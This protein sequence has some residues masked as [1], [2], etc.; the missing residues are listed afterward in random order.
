MKFYKITMLL[1]ITTQF[2][3]L[4]HASENKNQESI[5]IDEYNFNKIFNKSVESAKEKNKIDIVEYQFRPEVVQLNLQELTLKNRYFTVPYSANLE[6]IR[7]LGFNLDKKLYSWNDFDFSS[8]MSI[9]YSYTEKRMKVISNQGSSLTDFMRLHWFPFTVGISTL[10]HA[11]FSRFVSFYTVPK[12]GGQW[13]YQS[14]E[15]DG[16]SQ[17]F[18]ITKYELEAGVNI[19]ENV[20]MG[21]NRTFDGVTLNASFIDSFSSEQKVSAWKIGVGIK[22]LL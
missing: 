18:L 20:D 12:L 4:A 6:Q 11:P 10:Y 21:M 1:F 2:V 15:Q 9:G 22:V 7:A 14:G 19:W 5:K 8:V 16:I 13:L 17:S 3:F